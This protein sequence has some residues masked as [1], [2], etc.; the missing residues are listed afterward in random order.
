VPANTAKDCSAADSFLANELKDGLIEE[1]AMAFVRLTNMDP[2]ECPLTLESLVFHGI[3]SV[4]IVRIGP[5]FVEGRRCGDVRGTT[6][7]IPEPSPR[8][9][10]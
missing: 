2:H 9:A 3:A 5:I 8:E 1:L 7:G 4:C 6:S 10:P